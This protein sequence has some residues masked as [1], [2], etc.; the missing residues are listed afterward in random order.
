MEIL[1]NPYS[2]MKEK[3]EMEKTYIDLDP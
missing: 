1:A 2:S 3:R